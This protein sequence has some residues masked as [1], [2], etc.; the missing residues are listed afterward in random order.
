MCVCVCVCVCVCARVCVCVSF[1]V[2]V[3]VW[4]SGCVRFMGL[5][6]G[7]LRDGERGGLTTLLLSTRPELSQGEEKS[8]KEKC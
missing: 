3:C 2:Y 1:C 6:V 4:V 7:G 5:N 8:A